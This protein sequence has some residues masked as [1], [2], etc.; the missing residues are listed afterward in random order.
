MPSSQS[1]FHLNNRPTRLN[2]FDSLSPQRLYFSNPNNTNMHRNQ[3]NSLLTA[4]SSHRHYAPIQPHPSQQHTVR[5]PEFPHRTL[6]TQTHYPCPHEYSYSL[7]DHESTRTVASTHAIV[8]THPNHCNNLLIER[9]QSYLPADPKPHDFQTQPSPTTAN[10]AVNHPATTNVQGSIPTLLYSPREDLPTDS[11]PFIAGSLEFAMNEFS[12]S[13]PPSNRDSK[14]PAS[15]SFTFQMYRNQVVPIDAVHAEPPVVTATRPLML[16]LLCCSES[17][18][19]SALREKSFDSS[20][21]RK[22]S[23]PPIITKSDAFPVSPDPQASDTLK[24]SSSLRSSS[25][26]TRSSRRRRKKPSKMHEC[27]TCQKQFPRPSGLATHKNIHTGAKRRF[28][29]LQRHA[30]C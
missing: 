21:D 25:A 13:N 6:I 23:T 17:S 9:A 30:P 22:S 26:T 14:A 12:I 15:T 7:L 29:A 28:I 16:P 8:A 20:P 27:P 4:E 3:S 5:Y 11:I 10:P 1:Q 19:S 2:Q 24:S 18:L